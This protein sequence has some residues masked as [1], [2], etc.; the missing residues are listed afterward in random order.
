MAHYLTGKNLEYV[1][2]NVDTI[3][4]HP[5]DKR[6]MHVTV[7]D[8]STADQVKQRLMAAYSAKGSYNLFGGRD[9]T[10]TFDKVWK[11]DEAVA[12]ANAAILE[13]FDAQPDDPPYGSGNNPDA[14]TTEIEGSTAATTKTDYTT[15]IIIGV[16]AVIIIALLLWKRK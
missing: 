15:Y 4:K 11:R 12:D 8:Q 16:A 2:L 7:A 5:L 1:A 6:G 3:E 9:F 14:D 13:Y 10:I